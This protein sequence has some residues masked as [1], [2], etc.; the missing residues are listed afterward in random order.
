M[1]TYI[2]AQTQVLTFN[3]ELMVS[4]GIN[5]ASPAADPRVGGDYV[6]GGDQGGNANTGL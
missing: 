5:A 2:S 4:F 1:K 3:A 6:T